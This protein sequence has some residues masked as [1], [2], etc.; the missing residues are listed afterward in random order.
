MGKN[1][2]FLPHAAE[3][4]GP[5][6]KGLTRACLF[7]IVRCNKSGQLDKATIVTCIYSP[8]T[9]FL[10]VPAANCDNRS[11]AAANSDAPVITPDQRRNRR[12]F[13]AGDS[14]V[15]D[16]TFRPFCLSLFFLFS[17][18][19]F[20]FLFSSPFLLFYRQHTSTLHET[21]AN[22]RSTLKPANCCLQTNTLP[23]AEIASLHRPKTHN[24][25]HR[26]PSRNLSLK[27]H[28]LP[29]AFKAS[30]THLHLIVDSSSSPHITSHRLTLTWPA[31]TG[32]L[33]RPISHHPSLSH[34][35][36]KAR[37]LHRQP[38]QYRR[39]CRM[40]Q[41]Y[42]HL[43]R[44]WLASPSRSRSRPLPRAGAR[45]RLPSLRLLHI[46][47]E[48]RRR[49]GHYHG[50]AP[51]HDEKLLFTITSSITTTPPPPTRYSL[52]HYNRDSRQPHQHIRITTIR[53]TTTS[54]RLPTNGS[55]QMTS[56]RARQVCSR[57]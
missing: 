19:R 28:E 39:P 22:A 45:C 34:Q 40:H 24:R 12:T 8:A 6:T 35:D 26:Q 27:A 50:E 29:H 55:L 46:L 48:T 49:I 4:V 51:L 1:S 10:L 25:H 57:A 44:L 53:I 15:G 20:P 11:A 33:A 5:C 23:F 43:Q 36:H 54:R 42:R 16:G 9:T 52:R 14:R 37:R 2:E 56:W 18:F 7:A 38:P 32:P 47:P 3:L 17:L 31:C 21:T 13:Q 41:L 30:P